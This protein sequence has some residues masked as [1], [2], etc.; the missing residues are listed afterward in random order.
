M[1]VFPKARRRRREAR[2]WSIRLAEHWLAGDDN[3]KTLPDSTLWREFELW[4]SEDPRNIS[5]FYRTLYAW[6]RTPELTMVG[7][8]KRRLWVATFW[9]VV[10]GAFLAPPAA[11]FC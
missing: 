6:D 2:R 8:L 9:G 4:I 3:Y 11:A 7:K 1:P 10:L 5:E